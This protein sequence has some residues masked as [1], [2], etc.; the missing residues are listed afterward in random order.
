MG[1]RNLFGKKRRL[2]LIGLDGVPYSLLRRLAVEG[3]IP[4]LSRLFD[5]GCLAQTES[6][7]PEISSV[8][9]ST[10]MTGVDPGG[11]GIFGFV[12]L[13]EAYRLYFPNFTHLQAPPFWDRWG[14]QGLRS[15]VI[16][17]PS[18]FP[19]REMPGVLIAGF[20]AVDLARAVWPPSLLPWLEERGYRVDVDSSRAKE[21]PA[22]L[23]RDLRV[24]L[25]TRFETALELYRRERWDFLML[26]VTGTDR[27][28]H[29]FWHALE[30]PADPFHSAFL[31]YYRALDA[32]IGKF[33]DLTGDRHPVCLMSDHGFTGIRSEVFVNRLLADHG[34]LA[35]RSSAPR[36]HQDIDF[37]ATR[38]FCLDPGRIYL[39]RRDRFARGTVS[40]E[41]VPALRRELRALLEDL[42]HEGSPVLAEI[43][44]REELYTGPCARRGP[45]LV[46]RPRDGFD[47][48]GG[49]QSLRLFGRSHR[50]GMHTQHDAFFYGPSDLGVTRV[51]Q[52][53]GVLGKL[54]SVEE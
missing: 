28:H 24:L 50:T 32:W 20:V 49:V 4:N 18:T 52:V 17:L 44:E 16:N 34:W 26:T 41:D 51:Q 35:Y 3:V 53:A 47:L 39:N 45:D 30:D 2:A 19:A 10:F 46:L 29:F 8:S 1:L 54:L 36:T 23:A 12:D 9:W 38:A 5:Q 7:L 40:S 25:D 11:H 14:R 33:L 31:D 21:D 15:V 37:T 13:D 43:H 42:R 27:L 48:K 6:P 22:G